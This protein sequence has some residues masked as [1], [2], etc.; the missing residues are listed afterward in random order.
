M[1]APAADPAADALPPFDCRR[2]GRLVR[3][4]KADEAGWCTACR[5]ELIRRSGQ[6]AWA[7]ALVAA[8]LYGWLV[9]WSGLLE[10]PLMAFWLAVGAVLAFAAYKVGHRV[11]FDV[12]RG[13][14]TGDGKG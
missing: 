5:R 6:Y 3:G 13:R 12:L 7:W 1:R 11:M 9:W 10:S 2:C 14:A 4:E 8:L